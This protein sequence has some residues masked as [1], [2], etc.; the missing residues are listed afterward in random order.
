MQI[1][2]QFS[3]FVSKQIGHFNEYG[4]IHKCFTCFLIFTYIINVTIPLQTN[5]HIISTYTTTYRL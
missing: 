4:V 5:K 3:R 2:L 1:S